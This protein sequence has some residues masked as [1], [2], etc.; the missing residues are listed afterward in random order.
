MDNDSAPAETT[1]DEP[2]QETTETT[3]IEGESIIDGYVAWFYG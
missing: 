2:I 1:P 3:T